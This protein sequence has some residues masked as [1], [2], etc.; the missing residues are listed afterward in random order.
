MPPQDWTAQV[1]P[2]ILVIE[3]DRR[4]TSKLTILARNQLHVDL[5][6]VDSVQQ[7]LDKLEECDPDLILTL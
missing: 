1:V 6:I 7:T 4:Q 2:L 5:L 3:S